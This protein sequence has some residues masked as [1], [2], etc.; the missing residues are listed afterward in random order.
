MPTDYTVLPLDKQFRMRRGTTAS[1][2]AYAG[3]TGEILVDLTKN[4]AVLMS[5]TAGT[6]YPLARES[7]LI[8]AGSGVTLTVD[9]SVVSQADLGK[10]MTI[11]VN[12]AALV[13]A[14]DLL[15]TDASGKIKGDFSL[16]Y[17]NTT[18]KFSVLGADGSTELASVTVPSHLSALTA[19][20]LEEATTAT[21]VNGNTSGKFLHFTFTLSDGTTSNIYVNVTDLV[22]VYSAGDGLTL[23][24]GTFAVNPGNGLEIDASQKVAVKVKT[25]EQVLVNDQDGLHIDTTALN[26]AVTSVTVVSADSDNVVTAGTDGG[27]FLKVAAGNN[28]LVVNDDGELVV[29]TDMGTLS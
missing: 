9:G 10:D 29:P 6:N 28:L 27:A 3:A 25:G 26:N 22:D 13:A 7:R 8:V 23:T 16:S 21:P 1:I 18:G 14:N 4:T 19:A 2:N 24:S 11:G 20:T 5:G 17:N 12:A 15:T